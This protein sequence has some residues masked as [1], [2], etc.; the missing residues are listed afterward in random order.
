MGNAQ[1]VVRPQGF[2][3]RDQHWSK[4]DIGIRTFLCAACSTL[5]TISSREVHKDGH[6]VVVGAGRCLEK[7]VKVFAWL[8]RTGASLCGMQEVVRDLVLGI[9]EGVH[10]TAYT[11]TYERPGGVGRAFLLNNEFF[12]CLSFE[13]DRLSTRYSMKL[14]ITKH[15]RQYRISLGGYWVVLQG[16]GPSMTRTND[17]VSFWEGLVLQVSCCLFAD[18]NILRCFSR[19]LLVVEHN[20]EVHSRFAFRGWLVCDLFTWLATIYSLNMYPS[21]SVFKI[22]LSLREKEINKT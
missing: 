17:R 9:H 6:A 2:T 4:E 11:R 16:R 15:D 19:K 21:D 12:P 18:G 14:R 1:R 3:A 13:K 10:G 20:L 7:Y 22:K 8:R 5:K